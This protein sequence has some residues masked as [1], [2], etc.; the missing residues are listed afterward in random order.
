MMREEEMVPR[1]IEEVPTDVFES[2]EFEAISKRTW[3]GKPLNR[4]KKM[5]PARPGLSIGHH[6]VSA[7]TFGAVVYDRDSGEPLILSNN[8]V[9]A[10][11]TNGKDGLSKPGDLILQP[12]KHDGG[13]D[14]RDIIGTLLRFVPL[15]FL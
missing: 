4:K 14:P 15:R 6:L 5:R 10:N 8:H 9:L 1:F 12:G 11:A 7:G 3:Y 2:G 13:I